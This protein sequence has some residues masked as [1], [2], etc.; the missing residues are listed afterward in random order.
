MLP[1]I[2]YFAS[3]TPVRPFGELGLCSFELD[4]SLL[5][6]INLVLFIFNFLSIIAFFNLELYQ[7]GNPLTVVPTKSTFSFV[8]TFI[9]YL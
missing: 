8:A 4:L 6:I 2:F 9:V 7:Q 3:K 5:L 1:K